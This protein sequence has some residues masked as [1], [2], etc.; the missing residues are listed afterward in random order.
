MFSHQN[1]H[2]SDSFNTWRNVSLQIALIAIWA[3]TKDQKILFK[4][5]LCASRSTVISPQFLQLT[6]NTKHYINM[7][8]ATM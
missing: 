7:N 5:F 8:Y 1:F 6:R 2:S 4:R 3:Y